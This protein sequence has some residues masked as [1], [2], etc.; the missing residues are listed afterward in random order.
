MS[1]DVRPYGAE[2]RLRAQI[3]SVASELN[4]ARPDERLEAL[5]LL[6]DRTEFCWDCGCV[7]PGRVC[8]CMNDE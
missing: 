8:H 7:K 2:D 6:R 1:E 3:E 4:A 5:R